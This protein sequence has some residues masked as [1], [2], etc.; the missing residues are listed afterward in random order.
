MILERCGQVAV[1][2]VIQWAESSRKGGRLLYAD[3]ETSKAFGSVDGQIG[4]TLPGTFF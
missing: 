3:R 4:K 2:F 1:V